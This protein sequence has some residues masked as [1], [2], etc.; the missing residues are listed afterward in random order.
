MKNT[1]LKIVNSVK[2]IFTDLKGQVLIVPHENPDGDA[3]GSAV[4]LGVVLINAGFRVKII[5]PNNYPDFLKWLDGS[6]EILNFEKS[7]KQILNLLSG[8]QLVFCLDFNELKR[9]G[10]LKKYL[11]VPETVTVLIDH[12]PHPTGFCNFTISDTSYSSTAELVYDFLYE[13]GFSQFIDRKAAEAFFTGIMTD[14]GS[15]SYGISNPNTFRVLSELISFNIDPEKIHKYV[16][17]NF[18]ADRM[19]LLGF[20]LSEKLEF[21]PEFRTAFISITKDELKRYNF[22]PGDTEGFVNYPLSVSN[23][24]FSA[25]FIEKEG[26]VKI[27]FRSKGDFPVN[28]LCSRYFNGGG[29]KNAAGGESYQPLDVTIEKFRQLL[30]SVLHQLNSVVI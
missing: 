10:E 29:H 27:S 16:Y 7:K 9:A 3:I 13:A 20:C 21:L 19:R 26:M 5:T 25:L 24:V 1:D 6:V 4:G 30:P 18:S 15:F 8:T 17:D 23:I 28:D 2:K 14:T 12:H 11:D 22:V